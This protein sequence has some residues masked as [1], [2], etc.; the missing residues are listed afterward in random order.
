MKRRENY[1]TKEEL[2]EK[3]ILKKNWEEISIRKKNWRGDW[4]KLSIS[5]GQNERI[6]S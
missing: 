4:E 2:I 5:K 6:L 1:E 3:K